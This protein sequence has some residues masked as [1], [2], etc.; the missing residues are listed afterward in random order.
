MDIKRELEI[1][2]RRELEQKLT[3]QK[4]KFTTKLAH[5]LNEARLCLDRE[6]PNVEMALDRI[7][8]IEKIMRE[9]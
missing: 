6:N 4:Y 1:F 5:N 3:A 8:Q 7:R 2:Y 9:L